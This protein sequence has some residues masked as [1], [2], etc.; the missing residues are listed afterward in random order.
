[1]VGV[2]IGKGSRIAGGAYVFEDVPPYCVVLGN[3]G[4]IV[5]HNCTPDVANRWQISA[6][7]ALTDY[8]RRDSVNRDAQTPAAVPAARTADCQ[9]RSAETGAAAP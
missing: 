2:T 8:A 6:L 5:R 9:S 4:K 7:D 3:P 1:M